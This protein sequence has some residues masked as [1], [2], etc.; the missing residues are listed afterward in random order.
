MRKSL[1]LAVPFVALLAAQPVMAAE[2]KPAAEESPV[3]AYFDWWRQGGKM[4]VGRAMPDV[5]VYDLDGK[6][7]RLGAWRGKRFLMAVW[8]SW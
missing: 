8:A 6:E 4:A 1:V 3:P 2:D 7:V 5:R